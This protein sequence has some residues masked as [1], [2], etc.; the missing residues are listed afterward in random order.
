[1]IAEWETQSGVLIAWPHANTDWGPVLDQVEPVYAE[2][3]AAIVRYESVLVCCFDLAHRNHIM[4]FLAERKIRSDRIFYSALP[5]NDTWIRDYGPLST[6]QDGAPKLV[7]FGFNGW[8]NRFDARLDNQVTNR[9]VDR[10][11]FGDTP[12]VSAEDWILEGG[13]IDT[14][15][16]GTLLTTT[17]CLTADN[18]N[19]THDRQYIEHRLRET[20]GIR[21]MLWLDHGY[22]AGDDTDGHVDV[23][24]RFCN[25]STICHVICQDA[26]DAHFDA[27]NK[28]V[29]QLQHFRQCNK[30]AYRL[31]PLPIPKPIFNQLG[32]R[33]PA[34]HANF[35]IINRAVI[36]PIYDDVSDDIALKTLRTCFPNRDLIPIDARPLIQQ[37]G[38]IHCAT[39]Q[40]SAG[41]LLCNS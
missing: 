13:S 36:V 31:V 9:L 30:E 28:M 10:G 39:M 19:G 23:L 4:S 35:L 18:R 15:G 38:G 3:V 11:S 14:D 33:L 5:F 24:A 22:L 20:L 32:Q 25:P 7:K 34:S 6:L 21:R 27:L 40:V 37:G 12:M 2:L 29:N 41:V 17:S 1:M 26:Q 8:G 16:A